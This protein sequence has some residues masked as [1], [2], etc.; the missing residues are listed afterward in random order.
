M[1]PGGSA[2]DVLA[3]GVGCNPEMRR[4]PDRSPV[5]QQDGLGRLVPDAEARSHVVGD[6]AMALDGYNFVNSGAVRALDMS[7]QLIEGLATDAAIS[8]VLEQQHRPATG[9][10][11]RGF[12]IRRLLKVRDSVHGAVIIVLPGRWYREPGLQGT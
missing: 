12:E 4:A 9:L 2:V 8:T 1:R 10:F 11:N 3:Q 7:L 5:P 6:R